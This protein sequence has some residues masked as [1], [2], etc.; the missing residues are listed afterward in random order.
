MGV[1][2]NGCIGEWTGECLS[3]LTQLKDKRSL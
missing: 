2:V 3:E 1:Q